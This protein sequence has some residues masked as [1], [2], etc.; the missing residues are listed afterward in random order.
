MK[1]EV[2][3]T[4]SIFRR[5]SM[6]DILL[7]RKMWRSPAIFAG[8]LS[9]A[10]IVCF[11]MR[12]VEGAVFLGTTL[13]IVGLGM[14]LFYFA[15]FFLSVNKQ[16]KTMGLKRPQK[17]Y[18]LELTSKA[19]GIHVENEKEKADYAWKDVY[20]AYRDTCAVYLYMTP[21]RAFLL[22][23]T[24]LENCDAD[25]LWELIC[26]QLPTEKRTVL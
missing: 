25:Q 21:A 14:P 11:V 8:I 2:V 24:S 9:A 16:I 3:M 7:R 5:F 6:F 13:L 10:A 23:S 26:K 4:E 20:H 17:V 18:S 12:H 15:D 1:V 22:P 19:K